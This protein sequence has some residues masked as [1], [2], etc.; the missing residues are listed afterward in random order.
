MQKVKVILIGAAFSAD[1]HA[2]G[3]ARVRQK[4]Q[5]AAIVDKDI[6]RAKDLAARYGFT[7][8]AFFEDYETAVKAVDCDVVDVCLPNFLHKDAALCALRH[9]RHVISEKPLAVTPQEAR[10]MVKAANDAGRNI[11][12]AED[13]LGCPTVVKAL[14]LV[15]S[16]A[17]G[18]V[19]FIRARE[20]HCGSHSPFAQSLRFCG[21]GAMIHLGIHPVGLLLA[22]R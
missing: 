11:Y 20:C 15:K 5:I 3:Y 4:A 8:C 14:E 21:G 13:W 22:L 1:L 17:I 2:D 9:G 18:E 19:K 6:A 10:E 16:G 12:Y 7:D